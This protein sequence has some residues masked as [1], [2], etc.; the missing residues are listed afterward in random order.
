MGFHGRSSRLSFRAPHALVLLAILAASFVDCKRSNDDVIDATHI[1]VAEGKA[2][3]LV[4]E[5]KLAAILKIQPAS[6]PPT[7]ADG[8]AYPGGK[9][10]SFGDTKNSGD[11][12]R[13]YMIAFATDLTHPS[14]WSPPH[15]ID[16]SG[17]LNM[18]W[19]GIEE[20]KDAKAKRFSN[21][22]LNGCTKL[23]YLYVI[24]LARD[25]PPRI[26]GSTD[27]NSGNTRTVTESF[28]PGNVAGDV[29]A[30]EIDTG[31]HLGGFRFSASSSAKPEMSGPFLGILHEDLTKNLSAEIEAGLRK[32]T[33]APVASAK[34]PAHAPPAKIGH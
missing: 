18:C 10:P 30:F 1:T 12:G 26:T 31:K 24:R 34:P 2:R 20:T 15:S 9:P 27:E 25:V 14:T 19:K 29:V 23:K 3:G 32:Y 8:I 7:I 22:L 11:E 13:E 16:G 4:A 28:T 6:A 5:P 17:H 21:T 33:T